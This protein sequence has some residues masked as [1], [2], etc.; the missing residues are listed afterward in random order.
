MEKEAGLL[1]PRSEFAEFNFIK[2]YDESV[3]RVRQANM[4]KENEKRHMS[5]VGTGENYT[6]LPTVPEPF[7]LNNDGNKKWSSQDEAP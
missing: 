4:S 6:G 2:G 1:S 7:R 5:S 3:K